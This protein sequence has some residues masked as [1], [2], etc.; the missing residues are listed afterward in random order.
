MKRRS[1]R[2]KLIS[3]AD[4]LVR[5]LVMARDGYKCVR[6]GK[7]EGLQAAHILPKGHYPRMRFDLLNVLS[8]CLADHLHFAH[9]N[10]VEFAWWL[11][12][13]Y[14]GRADQLRVCAAVARKVDLKE[15]IIGLQIEVDKL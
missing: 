9:K 15:L 14:P 11:E 6:C 7:D 1:D 12:G 2:A 5:Q 13:K 4:Q 10:P 3:E 8:L